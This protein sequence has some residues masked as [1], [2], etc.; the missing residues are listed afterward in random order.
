MEVPKSTWGNLAGGTLSIDPH[1][2]QSSPYFFFFFNCFAYLIFKWGFLWSKCTGWGQGWWN[3]QLDGLSVFPV[4]T[5]YLSPSHWSRQIRIGNKGL[6]FSPSPFLSWLEHRSCDLRWSP[7]FPLQ[8]PVIERT[9]RS[10]YL[11]RR[12]KNKPR[13]SPHQC[14]KQ[15]ATLPPPLP[16][17]HKNLPPRPHVHVSLSEAAH[18]H[19]L[20][21][22]YH[23][24]KFTVLC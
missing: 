3:T 23:F 2:S 4:T 19:F 18:S 15:E 22:Y 11:E 9:K 24:N 17:F 6:K 14:Q 7:V 1:I 5:F 20:S 8:F 10:C 13:Q 12:D 16:M 21:V